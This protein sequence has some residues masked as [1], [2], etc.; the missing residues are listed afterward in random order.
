MARGTDFEVASDLYAGAFGVLVAQ[1]ALAHL[2]LPLVE[3][4]HHAPS[5]TD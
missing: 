5:A 2:N 1:A 4:P 3:G